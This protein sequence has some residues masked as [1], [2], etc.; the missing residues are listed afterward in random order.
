MPKGKKKPKSCIGDRFFPLTRPGEVLCPR[1][2]NKN[3][4]PWP[5]ASYWARVARRQMFF[6]GL[7]FFLSSFFL[8]SVVIIIACVYFCV[9]FFEFVVRCSRICYPIVG[10]A[11]MTVIFVQP[12][13]RSSFFIEWRSA[14][15]RRAPLINYILW[16]IPCVEFAVW[17]A[18]SFRLWKFIFSAHS[19]FV[20]TARWEAL[21]TKRF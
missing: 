1:V 11:T 14:R 5:R 19:S 7:L 10:G 13:S 2:F 16:S 3:R 20:Q 18:H 15:R 8:L 12:L 21:E 6:R 9:F 4:S 17:N